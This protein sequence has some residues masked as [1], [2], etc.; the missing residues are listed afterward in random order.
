VADDGDQITLASGFDTQDA[1]AVLGVVER[2][3]VDQSG[4]NLGW[5]ARFG[6][7]HHPCKMN[8]EIST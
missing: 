5:C 4:Q 6:W 8:E 3:P 7:L 1:E 2:Y